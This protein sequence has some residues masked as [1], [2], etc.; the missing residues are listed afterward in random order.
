[1]LKGFRQVLTD[2]DSQQVG[3][4]STSLIVPKSCTFLKCSAFS[5]YLMDAYSGKEFSVDETSSSYRK[6]GNIAFRISLTV[7]K[8]F[9]V[10]S[11]CCKPSLKKRESTL[12]RQSI[13]VSNTTCITFELNF[14]GI[15]G[16]YRRRK[17]SRKCFG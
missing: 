2:T 9:E 5:K 4:L 7:E 13:I 1:M 15:R 8:I 6:Y 12:W 16:P 14:V 17:K 3:L 10:V 11:H